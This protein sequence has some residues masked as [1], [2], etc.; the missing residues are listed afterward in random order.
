MQPEYWA[1]ARG[2]TIQGV[3]AEYCIFSDE[4]LL[5][6]PEYLSYE[7]AATIPCTGV[8]V[9][10]ALFTQQSPIDTTLNSS[11]LMLGTGAVSMTAVQ[12]AKAVGAK[13][14]VTSSSDAKIKRAVEEFGAE[15]GVNYVT[16]P[17][18]ASEI[19]KLTDGKG[20]NHVLEIAGPGTIVQSIKS[21]AFNGNVHLVGA[22]HSRDAD[23]SALSTVIG[24]SVFGATHVR[25]SPSIYP[26][27]HPS[28][29]LPPSSYPPDTWYFRWL[30]GNAGKVDCPHDQASDS[31][32]NR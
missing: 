5:P 30:E 2:G 29:N 32:T 25:S 19:R 26:V 24:L 21:T 28:L 8:T 16:H 15:A 27:R 10:N 12:L 11:V 14:Y 23:G 3:L 13:A 6:I 20:V 18:W 7:E 17:E 22:A 9:Y 4:A 1:L 31:P